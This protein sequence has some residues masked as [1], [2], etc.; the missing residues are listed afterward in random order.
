MLIEFSVSNFKSFRGKQTLSMVAS[1]RTSKRENVFAPESAGEKLPKL[2][3]V[4]AIYGA[5]ASGKTNLL[6]A[7]RVCSKIAKKPTSPVDELL[8]LAPFR[9]DSDLSDAP[10]RFEL[11]FI[12]YGVRYEFNLAATSTRIVEERLIA[13]PGGKS[14]LLYSRVHEHG[15]DKYTFGDTLEGGSPLHETWSQLTGAQSLFISQ[16]VANSSEDLKQLRAPHAWLTGGPL[17]VMEHQEAWQIAARDLIA[18]GSVGFADRVAAFLTDIDVPVARIRSEEAGVKLGM[19]DSPGLMAREGLIAKARQKSHRIVFTH[20]T[21]LGDADFE[22]HEESQG[23]QNLIAF[24]LPW[25]AINGKTTTFKMLFVDELDSSLHPEIVASLVERH[26]KA[27]VHSQLIFT[28]HDTHLMST[29]LLRRDQIWIV[30]RN[31]NGASE[32]RSV[33]DY[34]GREGE[35]IEKRYFQGRYRGIPILRRGQ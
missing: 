10:S 22:F 34:Q 25:A 27:D 7:L 3:K 18:D 17:F 14:N 29:K 13:Y 5:N 8:P 6:H 11:N 28:T 16:A 12:Q 1:P 31:A 24:W 30:D 19:L 20:S 35:D 9:F 21:A 23:T 33:H 32:L 2:L 26:I 4:A 15:T